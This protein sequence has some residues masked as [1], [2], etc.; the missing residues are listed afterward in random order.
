M[1]SARAG[2]ENPMNKNSAPTITISISPPGMRPHLAA[3]YLGTTPSRIEELMRDG[4]LPFRMLGDA[5]VIAVEDLNEYF[6]SVN[7]RAERR[8]AKTQPR[9]T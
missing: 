7:V 9:H 6:D 5:R 2:V 8:S 4:M 1:G 3:A